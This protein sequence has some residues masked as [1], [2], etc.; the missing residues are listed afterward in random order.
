MYTYI[1]MHIYTYTY[2]R[3]LTCRRIPSL[4]SQRPQFN[5]A[6]KHT[7]HCMD[8]APCSFLLA[9]HLAAYRSKPRYIGVKTPSKL[10]GCS[11]PTWIILLWT[12]D[13]YNG[14]PPFPIDFCPTE[15]NEICNSQGAR[16]FWGLQLKILQGTPVWDDPP[17]TLSTT[18][19]LAM[20]LQSCGKEGNAPTQHS[21]HSPS[22]IC[23]RAHWHTSNSSEMRDI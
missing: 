2:N 21:V 9:L 4:P 16:L 3:Y 11:S 17:L 20:L 6:D 14:C 1:Y 22:C 18:F 10:I 13:N 5:S 7:S 15:S 23:V 19:Q 8:P 12:R